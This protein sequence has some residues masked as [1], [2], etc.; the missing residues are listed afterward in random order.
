MKKRPCLNLF[1]IYFSFMYSGVLFF[2]LF[3]SLSSV[4]FTPL[5][6]GNNSFE[7]ARVLVV[8]LN[9]YISWVLLTFSALLAGYLFNSHKK[10]KIY[11]TILFVLSIPSVLLVAPVVV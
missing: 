4:F 2:L 9:N 11:F 5:L 3:L 1:K 8:N 7:E 6:G 10:G